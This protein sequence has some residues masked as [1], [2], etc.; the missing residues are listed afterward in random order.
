[1]K[2]LEEQSHYEALDVAENATIEEIERAYRVARASFAPDSPALYSVFGAEDA[3]AIQSRIEAA[4]RV[5]RDEESRAAYDAERSEAKGGAAASTPSAAE[6]ETPAGIGEL[7]D[8]D[9][10]EEGRDW[11]GARLR[12]ARL[13]RGVELD[14][15]AS[16]TK[17]S[18]SY[19]RCIEEEVYDDLPPPVYVRGFVSAYA[20]TL[21]LDAPRVAGGYVAR[22]EAA[23][24]GRRPG[25]LLGRR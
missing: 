25:R 22:M 18:P 13:R 1:M 20:K 24:R 4:Y 14:H 2:P 7:E 17:I 11:D 6:E 12:R 19:L 5:L 9:D 3:S 15:V 23:K 10:E 21:G 16:V 8:P